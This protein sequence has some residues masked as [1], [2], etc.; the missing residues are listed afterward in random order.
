[1]TK[2]PKSKKNKEWCKPKPYPHLTRK[3][4]HQHQ[5]GDSYQDAQKKFKDKIRKIFQS[6]THDF[7]PLLRYI[8]KEKRYKRLQC[9]K[10]HAYFVNAKGQYIRKVGNKERTIEYATHIDTQIYSYAAHLLSRQ[11]EKKLKESPEIDKSVIGYRRI[12]NAEGIG[13]NNIEFASD[14]FDEIMNF[15]KDAYVMAYDI[16]DFFP[17]LNHQKLFQAWVKLYDTTKL[18][19]SHYR[20]Y[21]AVTKYSYIKKEDIRKYLYNSQSEAEKALRNNIA[22]GIDAYFA[23]PQEMREAFKSGKLNIYTN[24]KKKKEIG[25]NIEKEHKLNKGIPQGLPTS[26]ILA[27]IYMWSFDE[28]ISKL[29][30]QRGG[31]YRRYSDD[32]II[33]IPKD[34]TLKNTLEDCIQ[35]TLSELG[36]N[37]SHNKTEEYS[38]IQQ[39]NGDVSV[40]GKVKIKRYLCSTE[41][42][43]EQGKIPNK[44]T[45]QKEQSETKTRYSLHYLGLE[46][47]GKKNEQKL[48]YIK[49]TTLAKFQKKMRNTVNRYIKRAYLRTERECMPQPE[50]FYNDLCRKFTFRGIKRGETQ[51]KVKRLKWQPFR[52][53]YDYETT[54]KKHTPKYGNTLSYARKFDKY[55]YKTRKGKKGKGQGQFRKIKYL[56]FKEINKA[57]RKYKT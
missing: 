8:K 16:K 42:C 43:Y 27:N 57:K 41:Q 53:V 24:V 46:F 48:V 9:E 50:I 36:L 30:Y 1:M 35:E 10:D 20:I 5:S 28:A 26:A 12:E 51:R 56:L 55:V 47:F 11:Y 23:T 17:S 33:L 34:D 40:E 19:A 14:F 6:G 29:V 7:F 4:G 39:P 22:Q 54:E 18:T 15:G 37:I 21:R 31:Q 25:Q 32:I 52:E 13:K 38:I 2:P 44:D 45:F 3:A 49:Q